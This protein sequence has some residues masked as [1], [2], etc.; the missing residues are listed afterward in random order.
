MWEDPFTLGGVPIIGYEV[1]TEQSSWLRGKSNVE[2][3]TQFSFNTSEKEANV[4]QVKI[5]DVCTSV[6][7]SVSAINEAGI[8][9]S[10]SI[11]SHFREGISYCNSNAK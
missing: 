8:G 2:N 9:E 6:Y 5:D 11:T 7:F 10:A 1:H 3:S 4:T